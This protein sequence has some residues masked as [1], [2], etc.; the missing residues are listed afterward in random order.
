LPQAALSKLAEGVDGKRRII[1]SPPLISR[2][3]KSEAHIRDWLTDLLQGY[4]ESLQDSRK[5]LLSR[6]RFVDAAHKVVGVGSV[7]TRCF[8]TCWEGIEGGDSLFL[9]VKQANASLLEP[10]LG[11]SEYKQPQARDHRA[12]VDASHQRHLPGL[13]AICRPRLLHPPAV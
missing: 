1:H 12:A 13:H 10:Y 6:Y 9:Q 4:Y 2:L 8:I 11:R 7:G 3:E 5:R